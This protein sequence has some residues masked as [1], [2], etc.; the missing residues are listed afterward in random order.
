MDYE[1]GYNEEKNRLEKNIE[2]LESIYQKRIL[3][4]DIQEKDKRKMAIEEYRLQLEKLRVPPKEDVEYRNQIKEKILK[5][6]DIEKREIAKY[7]YCVSCHNIIEAEDILKNY[8]N[9]KNKQLEKTENLDINKA[10]QKD[11]SKL[12]LSKNLY[13][14]AGCIFVKE[15]EEQEQSNNKEKVEKLEKEE[16]IKYIIS[17]PE[18]IYNLNKLAK[19]SNLKIENIIEFNKFEIF[20]GKQ[21]LEVKQI[22]EDVQNTSNNQNNNN[23]QMII[24]T[25]NNIESI[26]NIDNTKVTAVIKYKVNIFIKIINKIKR[27]FVKEQIVD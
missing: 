17:T 14:P 10:I 19:D 4:C 1:K 7:S 26:T 9:R 20:N 12:N 21:N 27:A 8:E 24:E 5:L 6:V 2:F 25:V 18:N 23:N 16:K 11:I 15:I 3:N 13:L 22:L